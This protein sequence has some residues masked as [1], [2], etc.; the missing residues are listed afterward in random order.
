MIVLAWHLR[1]RWWSRSTARAIVI[2]FLWVIPLLVFFVTFPGDD[3]DDEAGQLI[4]S[5][6]T[7]ALSS[8]VIQLILAV[9]TAV[10][11]AF[12]LLSRRRGS[13]TYKA[14]ASRS[15]PTGSPCRTTILKANAD[16]GPAEEYFRV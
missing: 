2:C 11:I 1:Y 15:R 16:S 9:G 10:G 6:W 7:C 14:L 3:A 5:T 4:C 8:A 12:L 13:S